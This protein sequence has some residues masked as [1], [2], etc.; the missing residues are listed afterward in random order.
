MQ[1]V[2][3]VAVGSRSGG[4]GRR[5]A[6]GTESEFPTPPKAGDNGIGAAQAKRLNFNLGRGTARIVAETFSGDITIPPRR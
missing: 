3:V 2:G 4:G 1:A 6:G 5:L